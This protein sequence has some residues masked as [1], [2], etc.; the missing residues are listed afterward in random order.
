MKILTKV[1]GQ[2]DRFFLPGENE[3][4]VEVSRLMIEKGDKLSEG[5]LSLYHGINGCIL[6]LQAT[7]K[8]NEEP[9]FEINEDSSE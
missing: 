4:S 3:G 2:D 8:I 1:F 9:S 7:R 6:S 5:Q